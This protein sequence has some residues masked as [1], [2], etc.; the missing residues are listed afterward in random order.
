M[1]AVGSGGS[2]PRSDFAQFYAA[3]FHGITVQV[4]AYTGDLPLAQDIA[5]EAFTRAVIRWEKLRTYD[6]PAAW[7]RRVAF[8]LAS[9]RW[10]HIRI[11]SAY[12]RR[13]REQH[14]DGP[15]PDRVAL[16]R[17]L[18][19]LPNRHRR[20]VILHYL[21]DLSIADIARQEGV[22]PNTVKSWLHRGRA[23]L[24]AQ[25]GDAREVRS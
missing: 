12:L 19:T 16:A 13:Q 6:D 17:A 15:G 3:Q 4:F 22:S 2:A 24:A 18:A 25:L 20:A 7:V 14:V 23:E 11:A 8:N 10:R 9:S 21:A 1:S 5:Q